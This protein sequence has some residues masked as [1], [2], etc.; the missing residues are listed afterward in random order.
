M[1]DMARGVRVLVFIEMR[2]EYANHANDA[3]E[4]FTNT[5]STFGLRIDLHTADGERDEV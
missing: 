4:E 1:T 5:Y 3:N 2:C